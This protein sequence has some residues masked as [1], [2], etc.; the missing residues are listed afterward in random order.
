M[1][2]WSAARKRDRV[3]RALDA[4][5]RYGSPL[6]RARSSGGCSVG[7]GASSPARRQEQNREGDK[8][9][10]TRT[11]VTDDSD[12]LRAPGQDVAAPCFGRYA[13]ASSSTAERGPERGTN[14]LQHAAPKANEVFVELTGNIGALQCTQSLAL[15][16]LDRSRCAQL[17]NHS[18]QRNAWCVPPY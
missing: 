17:F 2:L 9:W 14:V 10:Y 6:H 16:V 3:S 1:A 5:R 4:T 15:G 7:R 8:G 13:P 12:H 11:A 18:D